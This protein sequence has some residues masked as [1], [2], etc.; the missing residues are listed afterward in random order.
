MCTDMFH[1][2]CYCFHTIAYLNLYD[3]QLTGTI[4]KNLNLANLFHLDIGRNKIGGTIPDDIGT[5]FE[6]LK[7]LHID[8]NRIS[9]FLPDS[10][11]LMANGRMISLLANHNRL[12]GPVPDNWTVFNKLVQFNIHGEYS[13]MRLIHKSLE[14]MK[15]DQ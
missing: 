1:L 15:K 11:P 12:T 4:P 10:V 7:F 6:A 3:N 13:M 5:D 2:I 9:G 8:H 14:F